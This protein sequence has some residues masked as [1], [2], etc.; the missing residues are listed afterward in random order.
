MTP[1][2]NKF[3]LLIDRCLIRPSA[4]QVQKKKKKNL[5][6]TCDVTVY[7]CVITSVDD[8][9]HLLFMRLYEFSC[10]KDTVCKRYV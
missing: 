10:R 3:L 5:Y 4:V 7:Y 6:Y 9:A 8:T 2:F 1:E